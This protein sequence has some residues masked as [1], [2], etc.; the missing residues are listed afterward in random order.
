[1]PVEEEK[2]VQ[3]KV[4]VPFSHVKIY[5]NKPAEKP[6]KQPESIPKIQEVTHVDAVYANSKPAISSEVV[7]EKYFYDKRGVA[8]S[9]V[10]EAIVTN[11]LE[12]DT[13]AIE[14]LLGDNKNNATVLLEMLFEI[15]KYCHRNGFPR[16]PIVDMSLISLLF[17][18]LYA[19]DVIEKDVF[20]V[21]SED[22]SSAIDRSQGKERAIIQTTAFLNELKEEDEEQDD[23]EY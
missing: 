6:S 15:Q 22:T 21:W 11:P 7:I 3:Q 14:T 9:K 17:Q 13:S 23:V 1:M 12:A 8:L 2:V 16:V 4:L 10:I 5:D 18:L 20:L 19:N